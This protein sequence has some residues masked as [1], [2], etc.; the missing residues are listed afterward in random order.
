MNS[1]IATSIIVKSK[2]I[3]VAIG[4]LDR[5]EANKFGWFEKQK[6]FLDKKH[7]LIQARFLTCYDQLHTLEMEHLFFVK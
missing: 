4:W 2:G 7:L 6:K 3:I 1:V 5:L